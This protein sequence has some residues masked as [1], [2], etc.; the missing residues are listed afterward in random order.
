MDIVKVIVDM[1]DEEIDGAEN[2]AKCALKNKQENPQLAKVFH[3]ISCDE[4][5]HIDMLHNEV[6]TL[7]KRLRDSGTEVSENMLAIYD[8]LHDRQINRVMAIREIQTQYKY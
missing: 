1:I 8:Y 3:D 2:Y 6:A 4:L 5:R 7:I